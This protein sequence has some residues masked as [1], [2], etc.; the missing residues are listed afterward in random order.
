MI[1]NKKKLIVI[2]VILFTLSSMVNAGTPIAYDVDTCAEID[3]TGPYGRHCDALTAGATA[4]N[5]SHN[6]E[7]TTSSKTFDGPGEKSV[8]VTLSVTPVGPAGMFS[9]SSYDVNG[10]TFYS[11][12][13]AMDAVNKSLGGISVSQSQ[14]LGVNDL[15]TTT[16]SNTGLVSKN[17][18]TVVNTNL[19]G[20]YTLS[21]ES[22]YDAQYELGARAEAAED[23]EIEAL[24]AQW[25]FLDETLHSKEYTAEKLKAEAEEAAEVSKLA[26]GALAEAQLDVLKWSTAVQKEKKKAEA[27]VSETFSEW[28]SS[29]VNNFVSSLASFFTSGATTREVARVAEVTRVAEATKAAA[30]AAAA[31]DGN[32]SVSSGVAAGTGATG[33]PGRDYNTGRGDGNDGGGNGNSNGGGSGGGIGSNC[34]IAGTKISLKD[35]SK[36]I[37]EIK[38]GDIV[39]S[40]NEVTKKKELKKVLNLKQPL[41]NDIVKYTLENGK[42]V[43]STFDHPYYIVE[44]D[45][46][47]FS[48]NL[49]NKRYDIGRDSGRISVGDHMIGMEGENIKIIAIEAEIREEVVQTF[50]FEVEDNHNFYAN[51]FLVHNK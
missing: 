43:E 34:F 32:D 20:T 29:S 38:V 10:Q 13:D 33:A 12:E 25:N 5:P 22:L 42:T 2:S 16:I 1:K 28:A 18:S 40:F 11:E 39:W 45:I 24:A 31:R 4:P 6:I 47:S 26:A 23:A 8:T 7:T 19:I 15:D 3:E 51:G 27:E 49:T 46:A 21:Q 9:A 44:K 48:P 30:V 36:K 41:H 35:G 17:W 37:E 50:I 14:A